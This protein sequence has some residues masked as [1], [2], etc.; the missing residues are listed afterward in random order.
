[1]T[2]IRSALRFLSLRAKLVGLLLFVGASALAFLVWQGHELAI[3][4]S[5]LA[6]HDTVS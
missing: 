5:A 2:E 1:M 3:A 6:F 4:R